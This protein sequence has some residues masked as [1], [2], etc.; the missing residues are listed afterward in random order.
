MALLA[1]IDAG[2]ITVSDIIAHLPLINTDKHDI[3]Q[4][5]LTLVWNDHSKILVLEEFI[6]GKFGGNLLIHP[7]IWELPNNPVFWKAAIQH[8]PV[9]AATEF[10]KTID[11]Y[12]LD[13]ICQI[14]DN[15][16]KNITDPNI[17]SI[18]NEYYTRGV[19]EIHNG[20][21]EKSNIIFF[22]QQNLD[23]L[24]VDE[25]QYLTLDLTHSPHSRIISTLNRIRDF[26]ID[27]PYRLYYDIAVKNKYA[28]DVI[29]GIFMLDNTYS[30]I[31]SVNS[32]FLLSVNIPIITQCGKSSL[33]IQ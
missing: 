21:N 23:N 15:Y 30:L 12:Q 29:L 11:Q 7:N 26:R 6:Y 14:I 5:L 4:R 10:F 8:Q 20:N 24:S 27:F 32:F 19:W 13:D 18:I 31:K 2:N 3:Y 17:L 16:P 33:L 9:Y 22:L 25:T 28:N 1:L